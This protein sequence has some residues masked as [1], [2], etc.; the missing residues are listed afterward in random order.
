MRDAAA[1]ISC[2]ELYSTVTRMD[3][4]L[5]VDNSIMKRNTLRLKGDKAQD[6]RAIRKMIKEG[7]EMKETVD[8]QNITIR[9]LKEEIKERDD[10]I[11]SNYHTIQVLQRCKSSLLCETFRNACINKENGACGMNGAGTAKE[12]TGA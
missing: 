5:Q 3:N 11:S 10:V 9:K 4:I 2:L 12:S 6:S 8:D 7:N 1:R